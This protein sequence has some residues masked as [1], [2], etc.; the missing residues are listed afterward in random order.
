MMSVKGDFFWTNIEME[1][2]RSLYVGPMVET[3]QASSQFLSKKS[4]LKQ[5]KSTMELLKMICILNLNFSPGRCPNKRVLW[6][7]HDFLQT[8]VKGGNWLVALLYHS[9]TTV[10]VETLQKGLDS[11]SGYR[12]ILQ[13]KL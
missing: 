4:T 1:E 2:G 9:T 3:A 8:C 12:T 13:R 7:R 11:C 5:H 10:R 6:I